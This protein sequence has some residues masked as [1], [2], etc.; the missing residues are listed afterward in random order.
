M[1]DGV[2]VNTDGSALGN[3]GRAGCGGVF[4]DVSGRWLGGFNQN[5]GRCTT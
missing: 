2:V 4:R 3:P 1:L 5:L